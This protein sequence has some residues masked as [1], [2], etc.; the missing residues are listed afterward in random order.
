[1]KKRI[2]SLI[3]TLMVGFMLITPTLMQGAS[4]PS[5]SSHPYPGTPSSLFIELTVNASGTSIRDYV[6]ISE[7][8]WEATRTSI[9]WRDF[10]AANIALDRTVDISRLVNVREPSYLIVSR[11]PDL[12]NNKNV[13]TLSAS[14]SSLSPGEILG[15]YSVIKLLPPATRP[16]VPRPAFEDIDGEPHAIYTFADNLE[17]QKLGERAWRSPDKIP[18][19]SSTG[20]G[21][22]IK[23]QEYRV[24]YFVRTAASGST[25][26]SQ[27]VKLTIPAMA[28]PPTARLNIINGEISARVGW[29]A[30]TISSDGTIISSITSLSVRT[31]TIGHSEDNLTLGQLSRLADKFEF[32][33]PSTQNRAGSAWTTLSLDVGRSANLTGNVNDYFELTARNVFVVGGIPIQANIGG[34]WRT[35][36]NI[37]FNDFL[38]AN[39]PVGTIQVRMAGTRTRL[40]GEPIT[41]YFARSNGNLSFTEPSPALP[42]D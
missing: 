29:A 26:A 10:G 33:V 35:V 15:G 19:W 24:E 34:R 25:S 21:W 2:M 22:R 32:R 40:P 12:R 36:K 6:I 38:P 13:D 30:R 8:Q 17:Y 4:F 41:L 14:L 28:N 5:A 42:T 18:G 39:A 11:H 37:R 9:T 31:L 20:N 7:K 23:L 3:L 27:A 16:S 1:M